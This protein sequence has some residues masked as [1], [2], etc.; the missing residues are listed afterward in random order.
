MKLIIAG[1]GTGGHLFPGIAVARELIRQQP[2]SEVLFICTSK[3][4][5]QSILEKS[6]FRFYPLK[7]TSVS[8]GLINALKG[9]GLMLKAAV[10]ARKELSRFVPDAI[11]GVGGGSSVPTVLLAAGKRIPIFIQEQNLVMGKANRRLARFSRKVFLA[12]GQAGKAIVP[13][14]NSLVTG[15]PV[16]PTI[17]QAYSSA[18]TLGLRDGVFTIFALG[19]SQGSER[20]NTAV[21]EAA[22]NL[23]HSK[24]E[25]QFLHQTG[26][27]QY[28]E[29]KDFYRKEGITA[30]TA[31]FIDE[32][33]QAY[34]S[35]DLVVSRAGATSI[36]E[37]TY[38]GKPMVLVPYPYATDDHQMMNARMLAGKGAA[39]CLSDDETLSGALCKTLEELIQDKARLE[40]MSRA[41]AQLGPHGAA[42]KIVLEMLKA[43]G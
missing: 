4:I 32:I 11:L 25:F 9:I 29:I 31:A 23:K 5:D 43:V 26:Q 19:G 36:A 16:R 15:N 10:S 35:A 41:S 6:G 34:V 39:I 40:H 8:G 17:S 20:L 38:L 27:A 33:E 2:E 3:D 30:Y 28:Q 13:R 21:R 14:I 42:E 37:L 18:R 7:L 12:Y 24:A 22:L 1:G